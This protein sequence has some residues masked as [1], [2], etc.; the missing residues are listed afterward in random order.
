MENVDPVNYSQ[1]KSQQAL[2][3]SPFRFALSYLTP[4][5]I[6]RH[7]PQKARI[8]DIGCGSGRYALYFV[9]AGIRGEYVGVDCDEKTWA[10]EQIPEDFLRQ[11]V[12]LDAHNL[13][14]LEPGFDFAISLTAFEHFE[15]DAKVMRGLAEVLKKGGKALIVVPSAYSFALYGRH[16]FRRYTQGSIKALCRQ[17]DLE[18][19]TMQKVGGAFSW[20][21]HFFWFFPAHIAR[22][23]VKAG[24]Y[25]LFGA[26]KEKAR[27]RLPRLLF[28]L[29]ELGGHHLKWKPT[30]L[31]HG[32]LIRW[33]DRADRLLP[34]LEAGY[35][36]V[37][38]K[39]V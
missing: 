30:R 4:E 29:D 21:F 12:R 32:L 39:G 10:D 18:I 16:G 7:C 28:F 31:L 25:A 14:K 27:K 13:D 15:D 1:L 22:L 19:A 17:A 6:K 8:L 23:A 11:F 20:L 2:Y 24:I 33:A 37:L 9:D 36:F 35:I 26:N 38:S 34:F 5:Y 3:G